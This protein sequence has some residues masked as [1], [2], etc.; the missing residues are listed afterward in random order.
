[1][2]PDAHQ[3]KVSAFR[4]RQNAECEVCPKFHIP[5]KG[6]RAYP[7]VLM[8]SA[9][10]LFKACHS[11]INPRALLRRELLIAPFEARLVV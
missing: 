6:P 1:M 11:R 3:E 7:A 10:F 9:H 5:A 2:V 8:R 4:Q